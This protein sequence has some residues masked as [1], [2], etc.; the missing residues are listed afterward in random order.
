MRLA[1]ALLVEEDLQDAHSGPRQHPALD[2]QPAG[3]RIHGDVANQLRAVQFE[4]ELRQFSQRG[5]RRG[6]DNRLHRQRIGA[7]EDGG[8]GLLADVV[9]PVADD[10]AHAMLA[11][12][13]V[14]EFGKVGEAAAEAKAGQARHGDRGVFFPHVGPRQ[15]ELGLADLVT[16]EIDADAGNADRADGPAVHCQR[17]VGSDP[18]FIA[19]AMDFP[20]FVQGLLR[21]GG[22]LQARDGSAGEQGGWQGLGAQGQSHRIG[23]EV[24]IRG[25]LVGWLLPYRSE[26]PAV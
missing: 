15:A 6:L 25:T 12:G 7:A 9:K 8:V 20:S 23:G 16:V 11:V 13:E 14:G 5:Y 22:R 10:N 3:D 21:R 4:A 26:I 24:E 17:S 2:D 18:R 19:E 1:Q